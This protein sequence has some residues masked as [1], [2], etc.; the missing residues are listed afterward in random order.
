M[1][2]YIL[3][4]TAEPIAAQEPDVKIEQSDN[5]EYKFFIDT[6]S[7]NRQETRDEDGRVIGQYTFKDPN[8]LMQ[9]FKYESGIDGFKIIEGSLPVAPMDY[10]LP[11]P[12]PFELTEQRRVHLETWDRLNPASPSYVPYVPKALRER[13]IFKPEEI[14]VPV[15][16]TVEVMQA[17]EKHLAELIAQEKYHKEQNANKN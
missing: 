5:G 10:N 15:Q 9:T 17:R 12:E 2:S 16:E 3:F 1:L 11:V 7:Y 4:A 13:E 14:P 6:P 8:G